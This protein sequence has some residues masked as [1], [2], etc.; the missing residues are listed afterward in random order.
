[1]MHLSRPVFGL[2]LWLHAL[3]VFVAVVL[4]ALAAHLNL[5]FD[6][7]YYWTWAQHPQLSYYDHPP[8]VAWLIKISTSILGNGEFAVR[9]FAPLGLVATCFLLAQTTKD[10]GGDR[11]SQII[12]ALLPLCTI[13]GAAA[14]LIITPDTPLLFCTAL[15]LRCCAALY[16]SANP[17][18]WLAIGIAGGFAL[19]SKYSAIALAVGLLLWLLVSAQRRRYFLHWQLWAGGL[20]A[21]AVIS[22]VLIWNAQHDWLSFSK[23]GGRAVGPYVF[24]LVSM[25]DFLSAQIGLLTPFVAAMVLYSVF[26]TLRHAWRGESRDVLLSA[27]ALPFFIYILVLSLGM[28]VEANWTLVCL[29]PFVVMT[30]LRISEA[31]PRIRNFTQMSMTFGAALCVMLLAYLASPL[32]HDLGRRD[33]TQRLSGNAIFAQHAD[34]LAT[35]Q[36]ACMI[37][38]ND[39]ANTALLRYYL[40]GKRDVLQMN[41]PERSL[42]WS[43]P[44]RKACVDKPVM[45]ITS[46]RVQPLPEPQ[47]YLKNIVNEAMIRRGHRG[48]PVEG[49]NVFS[50]RL[51]ATP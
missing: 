14:G 35:E 11:R 25:G 27:L 1:M 8:L 31:W 22:P 43:L 46:R 51:V 20:L 15:F 18:W 3:F 34:E 28:K 17:N 49:Y 19:L 47:P 30:A 37:L 16:R 39:Y 9:F 12:A 4:W 7:A 6:E 50:A 13:A 21:L 48:L 10:F 2:P 42:G 45:I 23:Q 26:A 44:D 29:A 5:S 33:P 24:S 32:H 40:R 36:N 38:T 41:D